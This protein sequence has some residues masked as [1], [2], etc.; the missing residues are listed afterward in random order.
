MFLLYDLLFVYFCEMFLKIF[1]L[2][3][4]IPWT[5]SPYR[6]VTS[7]QCVFPLYATQFRIQRGELTRYPTKC[8]RTNSC[9]SPSDLWR[10]RCWSRTAGYSYSLEKDCC[11]GTAE[12][13]QKLVPRKQTGLPDPGNLSRST[14]DG[15]DVE[16]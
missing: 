6:F 10:N 1:I 12:K 2:F 7:F 13:K 8:N 16:S 14:H 4:S 5:S 11:N 9:K 3:S 15:S